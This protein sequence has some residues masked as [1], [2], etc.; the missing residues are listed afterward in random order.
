M[1]KPRREITLRFLAQP[2]DANYGG[3]VHGGSAM[4]W[5]DQAGYACA[6]AW[7]GHYCVTAFVSDINFHHSI[8]VGHLIEVNARIIYTG[9]TSMHIAIDLYSGDPKDGRLSKAM[10]CLMVFVAVDEQGKSTPVPKWVA[11]S[12]SDKKLE[13]YAL[14]V[15][16]MRRLNQKELDSLIE[17]TEQ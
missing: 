17:I 12:E 9:N 4:K 13:T 7:S 3:N 14:R 16:E 11:D 6:T 8:T 15:M 5:L 10:H 1:S 2:T